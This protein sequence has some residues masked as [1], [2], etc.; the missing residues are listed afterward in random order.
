MFFGRMLCF[1]LVVASWAAAPLVAQ[2]PPAQPPPPAQNPPAAEQP[3]QKPTGAQ[4][5]AT[6]PPISQSQEVIRRRLD[7]VTTDVVVRDNSG[8]FVADLK[9]DEFE[10]YEDGVKQEVVSFVLTHGGRIFN[11]TVPAPPRQREGIILPAAR[12]TNDA[13]GRIFIIFVDDLHLDFRNTGRI[14][15]LFKRIASELVHEGDMFA[16]VSS[17]PSSIEIP[18][19]YDRRRLDEANKKIAGNALKPQEIL[20]APEGA[21]GPAELKY[22]AHVAFSTVYD[23]LKGLEQVHNRRKAVIY[24]SNGYDFNPF[25]DSRQKLMNERLS[26]LTQTGEDGTSGDVNPFSNVGNR[27]AEADLVAE[28]AEL[29]RQANRANASLYTIDPRGLVG[30]PDLDEKIDMVE[31]QRYVTSSQNSLRTLADLTGGI[32]VVNSNDFTKALK[33]IDAETSDYY[34]IGYYSNNPDPLKKRRKIEVKISDRKGLNV[35]HRSEYRLRP[36]DK[37]AGR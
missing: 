36:P 1:A 28:L 35:F 4:Q 5:P 37:P 26:R 33:R 3:A 9:K 10:V 7:L 30:G 19:N 20:D 31:W 25:A 17:G 14:R 24:I 11:Q 16:I 13:A 32:A 23:M 21:D 15:D 22:R 34:V 12:P 27:F 2:N 29:T 6:K 8:Q 18:L